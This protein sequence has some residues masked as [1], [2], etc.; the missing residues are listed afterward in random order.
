MTRKGCA[1][2]F[3]WQ[4]SLNYPFWEDETNA[5]ISLIVRCLC[6][7]YIDS[8]LVCREDRSTWGFSIYFI[9]IAKSTSTFLFNS[10]NP[11]VVIHFCHLFHECCFIFYKT[12]GFKHFLFSPLPGEEIVAYLTQLPPSFPSPVPI[13]HEE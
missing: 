2:G 8:C 5:G 10:K 4:G 12:G 6:W 13:F 1:F 7:E 11:T 3:V 9:S